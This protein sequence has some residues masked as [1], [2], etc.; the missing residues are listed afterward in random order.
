MQCGNSERMVRGCRLLVQVTNA[1]QSALWTHRF[2]F[3]GSAHPPPR[4]AWRGMTAWQHGWWRMDQTR[5]NTSIP[6]QRL[7]CRSASRTLLGCVRVIVGLVAVLRHD[8][9]REHPLGPGRLSIL[10]NRWRSNSHLV[11]F[12]ISHAFFLFSFY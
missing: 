7:V 11:G 2:R 6:W 3:G 1:T 12:K 10:L 4:D 8:V 5:A 9:D